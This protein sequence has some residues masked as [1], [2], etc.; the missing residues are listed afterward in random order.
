MNQHASSL[1][2]RLP[3]NTMPCASTTGPALPLCWAVQPR[4]QKQ[5]GSVCN[6]SCLSL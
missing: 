1:D 2:E 6:N 5:I 4:M 3:N